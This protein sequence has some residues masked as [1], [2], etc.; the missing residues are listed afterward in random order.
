MVEARTLV[1][2]EELLQMSQEPGDVAHELVEG[3]LVEMA[4][5]G[6]IHAD[7]SAELA[8]R[9][10]PY[11]R[12]HNLGRVFVELG[13]RLKSRPDTVRT[14]DVSLVKAERLPERLR[15]GFFPGAPDLA[16]EVVSPSDNAAYL[17]SKIQDYLRHGAQR[18]WVVYPETQSVVV[19]L[20]DGTAH[21]YGAADTLTDEEFLPGFALPLKELFT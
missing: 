3:E 15:R 2:A 13:F 19:Y 7:I 16:V 6:E 11:A 20:L 18:V 12:Q 9:L 10:R 21:R 1:T 17:D 8:V 4:P 5:P 14:P